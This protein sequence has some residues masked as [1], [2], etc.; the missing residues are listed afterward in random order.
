MTSSSRSMCRL[1]W[2][3][4]WSIRAT[5]RP[6]QMGAVPIFGAPQGGILWKSKND[7][8]RTSSPEPVGGLSW[9]LVWS[10]RATS[11]PLVVQMGALPLFFAPQGAFYKNLK[12]W[13]LLPN[14]W[15]DWAEIW[16]G[17]LGQL[18]DLK[19]Y[20]SG[21]CPFLGP[22]KGTFYKKLK[23]TSCPKSLGRLSWNLVWS[24]E[25]TSRH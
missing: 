5:S 7:L 11:R 1:S 13:L 9:S 12:W 15:A 17:A 6:W 22:L 21:R 18:V 19:L 23:M 3:L 2:N 4:G 14:H 20:K 10:I 16:F 8:N 24:I 25:A